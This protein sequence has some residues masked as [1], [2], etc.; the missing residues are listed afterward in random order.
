MPPTMSILCYHPAGVLLYGADI[1][2]IFVVLISAAPVSVERQLKICAHCTLSSQDWMLLM[3]VR[4]INYAD[5][6][7]SVDLGY[8]TCIINF[9][10]L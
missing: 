1:L 8:H 10:N 2:L 4:Q 6:I 9:C 3:W 5:N 7:I